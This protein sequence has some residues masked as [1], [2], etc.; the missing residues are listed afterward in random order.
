MSVDHVL[1]ERHEIFGHQIGASVDGV[2]VGVGGRRRRRRQRRRRRVE[3]RQQVHET[4]RL[5]V[6][7]TR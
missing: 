4:R 3:Q 1:D 2:E 5:V 6:V 7:L